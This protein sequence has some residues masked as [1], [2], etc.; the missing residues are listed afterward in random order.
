[1]SSKRAGWL[2][3]STSPLNPLALSKEIFWLGAFCILSFSQP[4]LYQA[5][6]FRPSDN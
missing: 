4:R 1:M 2:V 5:F 6:V 3:G